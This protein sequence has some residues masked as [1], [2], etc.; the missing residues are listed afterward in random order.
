LFT[1]GNHAPVRN[2]TE[3]ETDGADVVPSDRSD[4]FADGPGPRTIAG[5]F[6]AGLAL[7]IAA[8]TVCGLL[9]TSFTPLGVLDDW[10]DAVG[11]SVAE[12]RTD[13]ATNLAETVSRTGDT[14][15]I[16]VLLGVVTLAF[17]ALRRWRAMLFLPLAMLAEITTFLAVNHLVRRPRPDVEKI[18]PIP[19]TFS[20]PSGHVAATFVCWMGISLLLYVH[21]RRVLAAGAA[22]IGAVLTIA[23]AWARVYQGM[24]HLLDVIL[25]VLMGV[26]ALAIAI[27]AL[28]VDLRLARS[29]ASPVA[30]R[31]SSGHAGTAGREQPIDQ[32]PVAP[33]QPR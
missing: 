13:G 31:S 25:G 9:I 32:R 5:R 8:L 7:L 6:L 10:D 18:G 30:T 3:T 27:R 16:L 20:F 33:A 26:G 1:T 29:G 17:V 11:T 23:M 24:H 2:S 22:A 4:P 19:G 21:R 14:L 28:C 12:G 15:P